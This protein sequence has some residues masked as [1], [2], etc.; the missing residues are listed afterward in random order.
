MELQ[1]PEQMH[2]VMTLPAKGL[3]VSFVDVPV[4]SLLHTFAQTFYMRYVPHGISST[5]AG[6]TI[7]TSLPEIPNLHNGVKIGGLSI[8]PACLQGK[9]R[10]QLVP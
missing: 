2:R 4:P 1:N 5:Q 8:T 3:P 9:A 10:D 7:I 6:T